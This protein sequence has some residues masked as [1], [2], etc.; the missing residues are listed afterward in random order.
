MRPVALSVDSGA[1]WVD[2]QYSL[3]LWFVVGLA[4]VGTTVL[5][6]IGVIAYRR[7]RSFRYLLITVVL[8]VLVVRTCVGIGTLL[9]VIPMTVHHIVEH[10][11]D[12]LMAALIL[13]AIYRVGP[14]RAGDSAT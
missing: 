14:V 6:L 1:A 11:F 10:G 8:G 2:G 5:F 12:F 13:Y 4:S 9:G 7:R 3:L